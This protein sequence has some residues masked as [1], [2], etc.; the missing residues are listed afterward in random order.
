[1]EGK[2]FKARCH[3][4]STDKYFSFD[5]YIFFSVLCLVIVILLATLVNRQFIGVMFFELQDTIVEFF[6]WGFSSTVS[7]LLIFSIGI[8]FSRY[9]NIRLGPDESLPEFSFLAWVSMLFSAGMG[10]GL[11]FFGVAEPVL[12]FLAPLHAEPKTVSAANE[13]LQRSL[14]HWGLHAW[15]IYAVIGLALAYNHFRCSKPL[16]I[17]STLTPLFGQWTNK[18]PGKLIDI[19]AVLGTLF[20]LAT[21]LGLGATQIN[22]G[23]NEIFG[24]QQTTEAQILII[25]LITFCATL[26]LI[27]GL[28]KGIKRLSEINMAIALMLLLFVLGIGS[29]WTILSELPSYLGSYLIDLYSLSLENPY[30][31]L[32]WQ[33]SWTVFYWAWWLSWS[34]FVGIFIARISKGRTIREFVIGVLLAPTFICLIWFGVFGGVAMDLEI[35]G[36]H[37]VSEAVSTNSATAIYALMSNFPYAQVANWIAIFLVA[38]FFITSSDSGSFVVDMLAS[39]GNPNPPV[40]QRIFWASIEGTIAI[41]LLLMGGLSALQAGTVSMGFPFCLIILAVTFSFILQLKEE[42]F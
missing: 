38:I 8:I 13:A 1:M 42:S 10:I 2:K 5:P 14:F 17:R 12:H 29:T 37:I 24:L 40:W 25:C 9:G 22:A 26:S 4:L 39:G 34:P 41:I 16:S 11:V 32:E 23:L 36:V 6:A 35:S 3:L 18:W 15:A 19:F 21:S 27:L 7:L 33:K 20:G 31:N 30:E 28:D